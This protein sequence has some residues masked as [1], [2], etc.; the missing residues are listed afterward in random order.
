M[1]FL[2]TTRKVLINNLG[3]SFLFL[4]FLM[5]IVG[6]IAFYFASKKKSNILVSVGERSIK[7][8]FSLLSLSVLLLV[9]LLVTKDYSNAYVAKNASNDLSIIYSIAALWAGQEGSLLLWSWILSIFA[10]VVTVSKTFKPLIVSTEKTVLFILSFFVFLIVFIE[11]PFEVLSSA[12][13]NGR[14][15][16]PI[17]QNFYMAIHP[18]TLYVGYIALSIP[19]G[20]AIGSILSKDKTDSWIILSKRWTYFSWVFL[21]IGLLLGSR[22]AYLEL[23]WGGYWAWD[24]VENV[25]LMPWLALTAFVHSSMAQESRSLLRKWNICLIFI[26]FFLSIFGTFITRSGLISSVH[27]FAQ[28]S[29]GPYFIVFIL[30]LVG[31][32]IFIY[33]RN[34]RFICSNQE[35]VSLFSKE[36]FF[37]FNNIFFLVITLTVLL[38][39]IFPILSEAI[40]GE[41]ILVGP[42]FYN[43][44]NFPNVLLLM[45]LMSVAP[46]IPWKEGRIL[47]ILKFIFIPFIISFLLTLASLFFFYNIKVLLVFFLSFFIISIILK[48]LIEDFKLQ[49]IKQINITEIFRLK[50]RRYCSFLIHF[51]IILAIIGI[52]LSSTYGTKSDFILSKSEK[53]DINQ[54]EVQLINTYRKEIE[55]KTILGAHLTL[56]DGKNLYS[57]Y[58]EQNLYKYEGNRSINK[59]TEVAIYSGIMKDYYII[60]VDELDGDRFNFKI[61]INPWVSLLWIGS[62]ISILGGFV[63]LLRRKTL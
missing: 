16:N 60:L 8:V 34:K 15:L 23:G 47:P 26:A 58:P 3:E 56:L 4:S 30:L 14:G 57:L 62:L 18:L 44:V 61:Y 33:Q 43:L 31:F 49:L 6:T 39:T 22:W 55:S 29:I 13:K 9:Y 52:T 38:G 50:L 54:Y 7:A 10:L 11:N 19:F 17:L 63:L 2:R 53:I 32:S 28:S 21:S 45:S 36:N 27:S 59:E 46:I 40:T 20:F 24:P 5:G 1:K 51:G 35:I 48:E 41:K 12:P 37:I 42:S 25:A